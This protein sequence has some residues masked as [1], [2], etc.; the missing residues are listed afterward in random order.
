MVEMERYASFPHA[1][2]YDGEV[3][4]MQ[5]CLEMIVSEVIISLPSSSRDNG[6]H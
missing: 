2:A 3:V 5:Y 6:S 4:R 1:E